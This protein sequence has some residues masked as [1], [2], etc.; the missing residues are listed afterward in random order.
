[1]T[2]ENEQRSA[3]DLTFKYHWGTERPADRVKRLAKAREVVRAERTRIEEDYRK[4]LARN[5][6]DA[7]VIEPQILEVEILASVGRYDRQLEEKLRVLIR[8]LGPDG[9]LPEPALRMRGRPSKPPEAKRP[10]R[11]RAKKL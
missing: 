6:R 7:E 11:S 4:S 9:G 3:G 1:M 2:G 8:H 10:R 5:I